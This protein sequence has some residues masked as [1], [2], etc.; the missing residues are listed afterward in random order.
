MSAEFARKGLR[1]P[2]N[3]TWEITLQCNLRCAHCLSASGAASYDELSFQECCHLV[4]QLTALKV[5]QQ[6][7][8]RKLNI[9]VK[10]FGTGA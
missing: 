8:I 9:F 10:P 4:D 3:V 6:T 1:A 7:G 2:V 5:F